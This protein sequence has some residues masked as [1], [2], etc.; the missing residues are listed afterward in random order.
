MGD[1]PLFHRGFRRVDV[2]V[3]KPVDPISSLS[4]VR[5]PYEKTLEVTQVFTGIWS[6][7]SPIFLGWFQNSFAFSG[8]GHG[9]RQADDQVLIERCAMV[10]RL[11]LGRNHY[12]F[13]SK[14]LPLIPPTRSPPSASL[15]SRV[16]VRRDGHI[17]RCHI[18][19]IYAM[20][21][22][23]RQ[24]YDSPSINIWAQIIVD[25]LACRFVVH[26]AGSIGAPAPFLYVAPHCPVLHFFLD[27]RE[28]DRYD[29]GLLHVRDG[30]ADSRILFFSWLLNLC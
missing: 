12:L 20:D 27:R 13:V 9:S 16:A 1:P 21:F 15:I 19:Y 2:V 7:Q 3:E 4:I 10:C 24:G 28:P 5:Q 30:F 25:L 29:A 23:P 6:W 8:G 22:R 14:Y 26:F 17:V 11:S 18:F